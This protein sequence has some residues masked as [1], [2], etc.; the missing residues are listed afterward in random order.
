MNKGKLER[1]NAIVSGGAAGAGGAASEIFAREGAFVA[2][3]DIQEKVGADLAKR[4]CDNNGKAFF[5]K[6]DVSISVDTS[7][8]RYLGEVK[9]MY[10][11]IKQGKSQRIPHEESRGNVATVNALLRSANEARIM[12]V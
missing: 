11:A 12:E 4:I 6:C 5:I 3:V 10:E 1:K 7:Q 9:D 2:I 8:H